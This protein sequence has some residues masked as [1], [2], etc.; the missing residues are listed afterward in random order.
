VRCLRQRR[1]VR[2]LL[3]SLA[4]TPIAKYRLEFLEEPGELRIARARDRPGGESAP[5]VCAV[6]IWIELLS[7]LT[8]TLTAWFAAS[9]LG[10]A[11]P[12]GTLARSSTTSRVNA[13]RTWSRT[14]RSSECATPQY[15]DTI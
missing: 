8:I 2:D 10:M 9:A 14:P 12:S 13:V 4:V 6:V 11:S 1:E 15:R 5:A 3:R 7:P